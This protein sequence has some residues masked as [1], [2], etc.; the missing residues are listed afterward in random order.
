MSRKPYV[1]DY[2]PTSDK[3]R[4]AREREQ[5]IRST[6]QPREKRV[7]DF[8]KFDKPAEPEPE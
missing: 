6:W 2:V 4:D 1:P 3:D 8:L 7:P 5:R